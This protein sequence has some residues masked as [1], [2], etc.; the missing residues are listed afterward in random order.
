M[1]TNPDPFLK[2]VLILCGLAIGIIIG[3]IYAIIH[4]DITILVIGAI[5]GP[6]GGSYV[7]DLI[8]ED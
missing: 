5:V 7:H 4:D 3:G 1:K 6:L 2:K 8:K